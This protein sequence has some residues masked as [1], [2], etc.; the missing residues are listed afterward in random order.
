MRL[1]LVGSC[2]CPLRLSVYFDF[3]PLGVFYSPVYIDDAVLSITKRMQDALHAML[4]TACHYI[5]ILL[6][7][8][9]FYAAAA[10]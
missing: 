9:R 3:A 8:C 1:H 7:L 4:C 2:S 10:P 6:K 5:A